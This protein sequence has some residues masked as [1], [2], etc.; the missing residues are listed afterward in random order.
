MLIFAF[1]AEEREQHEKHK[2]IVH[3]QRLLYQVACKK[4]QSHL[5]RVA[6]IK[7]IDACAEQQRDAYPHRS[8]L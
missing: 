1:D 6:W 4:L 5:V 8:H 2:Q 3:R 7:E